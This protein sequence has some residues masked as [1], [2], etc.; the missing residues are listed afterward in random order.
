VSPSPL[1]NHIMTYIKNGGKLKLSPEQRVEAQVA[2]LEL[3]R[4]LDADP[5]AVQALADAVEAKLGGKSLEDYRKA[6]RIAA[7]FSR[8]RHL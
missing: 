7:G 6:L 3:L 2:I 5:A 4:D 1:A 8:P